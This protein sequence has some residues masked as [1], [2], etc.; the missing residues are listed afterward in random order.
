MIVLPI[1]CYGLDWAEEPLNLYTFSAV[2][3]LTGGD[4]SIPGEG[5]PLLQLS[6][7]LPDGGA[8]VKVSHDGILLVEGLKCEDLVVD[9]PAVWEWAGQP[10]QAEHQAILEHAYKRDPTQTCALTVFGVGVIVVNFR[11]MT[12]RNTSTGNEQPVQRKQDTRGARIKMYKQT[13][14]N[15]VVNIPAQTICCYSDGLLSAKHTLKDFPIDGPFSINPEHQIFM[16]GAKQK[17]RMLGG[18]CEWCSIEP[19]A[20]SDRDIKQMSQQLHA[21]TDWR[22]AHC[23]VVNPDSAIVCRMCDQPRNEDGLYAGGGVGGSSGSRTFSAD[24]WGGGGGSGDGTWNCNCGNQ[25]NAA[26]TEFC[27][28][29]Q[30]PKGTRF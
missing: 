12:Q 15:V 3:V 20:L 27:G 7:H 9:T 23:S 1:G 14:V 28:F 29:C 22:C 13:L 19:N 30:S 4:G 10:F 24:N 16:F 2:V 18:S 21:F 11:T 6:R 8:L 17:E 5:Y 26:G 25:G